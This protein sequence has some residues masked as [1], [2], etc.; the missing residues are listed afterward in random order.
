MDRKRRSVERGSEMGISLTDLGVV[1]QLAGW[2]TPNASEGSGGGRAHR[3]GDPDHSSDLRDFA[4]LAG[5]PTPTTEDHKRDGPLAEARV[6][7]DE[8]KTTDQRLRNFAQL[9]GWPTPTL[10]GGGINVKPPTERHEGG[11]DLDGAVTLAGWP[12]PQGADDNKSRLTVDGMEREA[13]REDRCSSLAVTAHLTGW[14]SPQS[15]DWKSG[16]TGGV[17]LDHN[18]RPLSEV[19]TLAGWATP[20]REDGESSGERIDRGVSDTLTSQTRLAGWS[21]PQ[22]R[23]HFPAHTP[24]Y[25]AAKVKEGH[26]MMNLNDEVMLTGWATP[27]TP[28]GGRISGNAE[29]IG[30]KADGSKAQIGLENQAKLA[31]WAT[32]TMRDSTNAANA[33]CTRFDPESEHH[34]G[35]TL[36]DQTR[37][38][39]W[40]TPHSPREH[41]S[42]VSES[43]YLGR[44]AQLTGWP[45]PMAGTPS[46]KGYNAAG[47]NDSSR[48]TQEVCQWPAPSTDSGPG[49]TG[50]LRGRSG[51]ATVPASG[52]LH[53]A[54]SLWLQGLPTV[55]WDCAVRAMRSMPSRRRGSSAPGSKKMRKEPDDDDE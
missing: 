38:T 33:T 24:E 9:A 14:P 4:M 8:M 34:D 50:F 36:I 22:K 2:R 12:T 55:F 46:Q 48:V 49:P 1:S 19:A 28:N 40:P 16:E 11:M 18:S 51:W 7:T 10:P 31:G 52:Q 27:N 26:G 6:G 39:G 29:D 5:W 23:D 15:R 17:P 20:T 54:F 37:L 44:E 47:N 32:P 3:A 30:K 43:T 53:P 13:Q 25:V 41:D 42:S 21:T 35:W 45:T